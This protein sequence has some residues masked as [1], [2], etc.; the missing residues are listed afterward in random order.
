MERWSGKRTTLHLRNVCLQKFSG[1]GEPAIALETGPS[2]QVVVII[3]RTF[4]LV[5]QDKKRV[6]ALGVIA[7]LLGVLATAAIWQS[8]Q[9]TMA[10]NLAEEQRDRAQR[11]LDQLTANA[12]AR[13]MAFA[14]RAQAETSRQEKSLILP[15]RTPGCRTSVAQTSSSSYPAGTSTIVI[16]QPR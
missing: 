7:L 14:E 10:R 8:V 12:N 9:A 1:S 13:V 15:A 16:S 2:D 3:R 5:R 6:N 4:N 11:V